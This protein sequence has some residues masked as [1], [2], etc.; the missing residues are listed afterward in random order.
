M[1][2]SK[3]IVA[4]MAGNP[5]RDKMVKYF[6]RVVTVKQGEPLNG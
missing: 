4:A 5:L 6:S 1:L 2:S 3:L